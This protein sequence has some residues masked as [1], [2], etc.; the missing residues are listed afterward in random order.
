MCSPYPP[1]INDVVCVWSIS[2]DPSHPSSGQN[3]ALWFISHQRPKILSRP[4]FL[5]FQRH[6][7]AC[8]TSLQNHGLHIY[9]L[10]RLD[11]FSQ[12]QI[13]ADSLLLYTFPANLLIF[14]NLRGGFGSER[15]GVLW[16]DIH[17][18]FWDEFFNKTLF[19]WIFH[20]WRPLGFES[21][22]FLH[23]VRS[24]NRFRCASN[25]PWGT[26]NTIHMR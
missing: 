11:V 24:L 9:N 25:I 20:E 16:I 12:H 26:M 13:G 14:H 18:I 17:Q 19:L 8:E 2:Q 4:R 5:S 7:L 22:L 6:T 15:E 23:R 3:Q 21:V 10:M 1:G